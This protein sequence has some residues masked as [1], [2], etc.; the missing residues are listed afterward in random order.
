MPE[1]VTIPE[2]ARR[3]GISRQAV[4]RRL[5]A[6]ELTG[7]QVPRP[8]GHIWLIA[9]PEGAGTSRQVS[10]G[11]DT[12]RHVPTGAAQEV[13]ASPQM[14]MQTARAHEM[15]EYTA[16][17]LEPLHARLAEQAEEL[18]RV[19]AELEQA[20][21]QLAEATSTNGRVHENAA[22]EGERRSWWQ[23][24]VAWS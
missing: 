24:L 12:Y 6:G 14:A 8:Q 22:P 23:R 18:G 10:T 17:L 3:L 9:L 20:R 13:P 7:R 5:K 11:A 2:A 21:A 15:A 4:R 19:K 16:A 1:D